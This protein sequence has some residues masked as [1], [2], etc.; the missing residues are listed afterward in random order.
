MIGRAIDELGYERRS[1]NTSLPF[2][3]IKRLSNVTERA[4]AAEGRS[5]FSDRI[6][7]GLPARPGRD[8]DGAPQA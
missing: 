7:A 4:K 3:E 2:E 8:D 1:I 5:D 6:R